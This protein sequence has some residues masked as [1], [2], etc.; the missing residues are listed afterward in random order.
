MRF[1][2]LPWREERRHQKKAIFNRLV[3]LHIALALSVVLVVWFINE[4]K[5]NIQSEKKYAA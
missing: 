3:L 4:E 2:F 1:N 5:L